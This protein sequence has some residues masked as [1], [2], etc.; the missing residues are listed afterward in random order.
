MKDKDKKY[1]RGV[2]H[3]W[4]LFQKNSMAEIAEEEKVEEEEKGRRRGEGGGGQMSEQKA[5]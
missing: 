4:L 5:S 3:S 1:E 2:C